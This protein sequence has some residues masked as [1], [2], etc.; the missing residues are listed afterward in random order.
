MA[1]YGLS[2][3]PPALTITM[4]PRACAYAIVEA[5]V[6]FDSRSHAPATSNAPA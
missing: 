5:R 4:A 2:V 3:E 6:A 1:V